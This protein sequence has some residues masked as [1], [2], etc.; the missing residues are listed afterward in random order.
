MEGY[1]VQARVKVTVRHKEK[2]WLVDL[3][4]AVTT[5]CVVERLPHTLS[6]PSPISTLAG[7]SPDG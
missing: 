4:V 2:D 1:G 7:V 3:A 5:A 6:I